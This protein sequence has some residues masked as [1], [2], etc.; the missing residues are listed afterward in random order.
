[1]ADA[2]RSGI[3]LTGATGR[4]A[5]FALLCAAFA[6]VHAK[7]LFGA[8]D[9]EE[10]AKKAK[11]EWAVTLPAYPIPENLLPFSSGPTAT[12]EFAIDSKSLAV[13]ADEVRY[14]LVTTSKAGARNVSYEGIRC[15]S[16]ETK[17]YAFGHRDGKWVQAQSAAWMP[18]QF[19]SANRPQAV[20][21]QEYLCL[22]GTIEGKAKDMLERIRYG[23]SLQEIKYKAN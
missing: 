16:F 15:S 4:L 12:Q 3:R 17:R 20:L 18:I 14:T 13:G 9:A 8:D 21:A 10:K 5:L 2:L 11:V 6:G 7:G 23:Q 22:G 1:M 19:Y